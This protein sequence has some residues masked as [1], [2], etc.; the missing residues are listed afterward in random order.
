MNQTLCKLEYLETTTPFKRVTKHLYTLTLPR[1]VNLD[2]TQE[3]ATKLTHYFQALMLLPLGQDLTLRH[4][5]T[6][7]TTDDTGHERY[8]RTLS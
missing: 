6:T 2:V 8:S 7:R 4:L 1:S 5:K 3:K